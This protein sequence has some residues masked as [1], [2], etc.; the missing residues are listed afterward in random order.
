MRESL[1]QRLTSLRRK[2]PVVED[3]AVLAS[4]P[5]DAS[6]E[7]RTIDLYAVKKGGTFPRPAFPTIDAAWQT[8]E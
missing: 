8:W 5:V 1:R 6:N 2:Y 7:P 4:V 3:A